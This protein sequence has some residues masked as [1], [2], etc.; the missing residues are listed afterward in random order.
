MDGMLD[1]LVDTIARCP[2]DVIEAFNA[3]DGNV[4]LERARE[5]WTGK[6]LSINFPSS[7]HIA[8]SERIRQ[9]TIDILRD[10]APGN[11]FIMGITEDVP[12]R[13]VDRSFTAIAETLNEYG[14]CPI[15]LDVLPP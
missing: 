3:L 10:I 4:S 5:A 1:S 14:R 15:S 12:Y 13:D 8:S 9:T 2:V 7:V 11:G 6:A